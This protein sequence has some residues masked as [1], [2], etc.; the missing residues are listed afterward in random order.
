MSH[1]TD[2]LEIST[3]CSSRSLTIAP[4]P[5]SA[6]SIVS[7]HNASMSQNGEYSI[8]SQSFT[9]DNAS[10]G[11]ITPS[12]RP[13]LPTSV[14][15][16]R[17]SLP[18][19]TEPTTTFQMTLNGMQTGASGSLQSVPTVAA[20]SSLSDGVRTQT[21]SIWLTLGFSGIMCIVRL[22]I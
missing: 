18:G 1:Q 10:P 21:V 3:T 19:F 11:A 7:S 4:V 5:A 20:S 9:T 13:S 8:L 12:T 15:S 14:S 2:L 16:R 22:I 6:L 17:L